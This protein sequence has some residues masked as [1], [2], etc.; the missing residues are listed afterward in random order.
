MLYKFLV[1]AA[2]FVILT[3]VNKFLIDPLW[4]ELIFTAVS[5][6]AMV[7]ILGKLDRSPRSEDA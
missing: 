7:Y 2:W 3:A 5:A 6:G 4:G 1:F